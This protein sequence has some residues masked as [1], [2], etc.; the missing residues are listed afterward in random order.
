[1]TPAPV[2]ALIVAAARH[3]VV[4]RRHLIAVG[5]GAEAIKHRLANHRLYR[6]H[7]G[8]YAIG[9]PHLDRLGR[10]LAAVLACG[11]G[12]V[13]SHRSAAA[14]WGLL[15]PVAGPIEV[16]VLGRWSS[17][18]AGIRVHAMR[19]LL[20]VDVSQ[21]R[22]IPCTTVERTLI[23]IAGGPA[24]ELERAVEQAFALRLLGR[25]RMAEALARAS[26]RRGVGELR[27]L[28]GRLLDDLPLTRS[29]LERRFRKLVAGAGLPVPVVNRHR[30][31]HRVDFAWPDRRLVIETDGRA[32]HDNPYAFHHD[33]ARDLDLE[34]AGWHVI[35][36]S[37]WQVVEEPARVVEL[38]AKRL[39]ETA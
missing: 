30:A 4:A 7:R 8:V 22:G 26:G 37:W 5:V 12:A 23:D 29:E 39:E 9:T 1:L 33:R 16:T 19:S 13:L 36:L 21:T 11:D 6:V 35:R 17:R 10:W 28:L 14:L 31:R 18:R 2:D 32:T 3:R 38:L 24:P 20:R 25:N 15:N 27:R 34:L